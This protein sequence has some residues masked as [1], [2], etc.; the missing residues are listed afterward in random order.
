MHT[1]YASIV[2][3]NKKDLFHYLSSLDSLK[4]NRMS[5]VAKFK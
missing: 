4:R 5:E 1:N 2:L 3:H